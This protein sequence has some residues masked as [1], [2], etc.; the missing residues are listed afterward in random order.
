V[1]LA[2]SFP[3]TPPMPTGIRAISFQRQPT[4]AAA[5][6]GHSLASLSAPRRRALS[7]G[8]RRWPKSADGDTCAATEKRPAPWRRSLSFGQVAVRFVERARDRLNADPLPSWV[9]YA[10]RD[11]HSLPACPPCFDSGS[12][13]K[14]LVE[15]G[16]VDHGASIDSLARAPQESDGVSSASPPYATNAHHLPPL[17]RFFDAGSSAEIMATRPHA[18]GEASTE[19]P[20]KTPLSRKEQDATAAMASA[21]T[22]ALP[23]L[24]PAALQPCTTAAT[25]S[26]ACSAEAVVLA[27]ATGA[28]QPAKVHMGGADPDPRDTALDWLARQRQS[29]FVLSSRRS[30]LSLPP[31]SLLRSLSRSLSSSLSR[32]RS[33]R[34]SSSHAACDDRQGVVEAAVEVHLSSGGGDSPATSRPA[35]HLLVKRVSD[36]TARKPRLPDHSEFTARK[37]RLPEH[38]DFTARKPRLPDRSV[39]SG[40]ARD[41]P[42]ASSLDRHPPEAARAPGRP[43]RSGATKLH[44]VPSAHAPERL[45][46]VRP[47]TSR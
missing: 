12:S 15:R 30:S 25:A 29:S 14:I 34:A 26:A 43:A 4:L 37:P 35:H 3:T 8:H 33:G 20:L 17:P 19:P 10:T 9:P 1:A 40:G 32:S 44:V 21:E 45:F 28:H 13:T 7:F 31:S 47:L 11:A 46:T 2:V 24:S 27:A 18:C 42:M 23:P 6:D 36:F 5:A 41:A 22:A 16:L 38:S 39:P